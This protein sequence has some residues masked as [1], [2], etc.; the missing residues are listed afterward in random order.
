ML[1]TQLVHSRLEPFVQVLA[2]RFLWCF[3]V[4]FL[5]CFMPVHLMYI[6]LEYIHKTIIQSSN[7]TV[8]MI[9]AKFLIL[10]L[11]M[12]I[13]LYCFTAFQALRI[14]FDYIPIRGCCFHQSTSFLR[15]QSLI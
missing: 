9:I 12:L 10:M 15:E 3:G 11:W 6:L 13:L 5:M 7:K 4:C 2:L 14:T 8:I 1:Y